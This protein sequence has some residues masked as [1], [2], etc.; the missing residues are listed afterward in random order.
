MPRTRLFVVPLCVAA[1]ALSVSACDGGTA[2]S[3]SAPPGPT[4]AAT[5]V[6]ARQAVEALLSDVAVGE[7]VP[8]E[9]LRDKLAAAVT[10]AGSWR[11]Q[12]DDVWPVE[13]TTVLHQ[14]GQPA[15]RVAGLGDDDP[16]SE[17]RLV[18]DEL[19]WL[20]PRHPGGPR[21]VVGSRRDLGEPLRVT[22]QEVDRTLKIASPLVLVGAVAPGE[23]TVVR[24]VGKATT[25]T[26][27][28]AYSGFTEVIGAGPSAHGPVS[29][30]WVIEGGLPVLV[31]AD[32]EGSE[33]TAFH[34]SRWGTAGPVETPP[35]WQV[36][37]RREHLVTGAPH[38][39]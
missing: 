33:P 34:Y 35:A 9:T 1:L 30:T 31:R 37:T 4:G 19:Y 15:T 16:H 11:A 8:A 23:A 28:M 22:D 27:Q 7:A 5:P 25:V 3:E 29:S 26:L 10:E 14:H 39:H 24:R 32:F 6:T 13:V 36:E 20:E 17:T 18:G 12:F 21:W 2:Q 38:L